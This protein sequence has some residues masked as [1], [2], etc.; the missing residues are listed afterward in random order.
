MEHDER[1]FLIFYHFIVDLLVV[2]VRWF[3]IL[4]VVSSMPVA[5]FYLDFS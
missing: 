5:D 3:S 2:W 1:E 4:E